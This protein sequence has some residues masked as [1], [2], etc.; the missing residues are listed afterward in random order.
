M[1]S[2]IDISEIKRLLENREFE[3]KIL[4]IPPMQFPDRD[5]FQV[6]GML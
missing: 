3:A 1:N 2:F 6:Y 5:I 4:C